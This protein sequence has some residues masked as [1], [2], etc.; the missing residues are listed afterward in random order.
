MGERRGRRRAT[1]I[2]AAR[3]AT[4]PGGRLV[5]RHCVPSYISG[6]DAVQ[7]HQA[8]GPRGR[9]VGPG[10]HSIGTELQPIGRRHHPIGRRIHALGRLKKGQ[11]SSSDAL[12]VPSDGQNEA[13]DAMDPSSDAVD[14]PSDAVDPP[15]DGVFD[16]KERVSVPK[17]EKVSKKWTVVKLVGPALRAGRGFGEALPFV[18]P[19]APASSH[20]GARGATRPTS[21][22]R[23][24]PP[25]LTRF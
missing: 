18:R 11:E 1:K 24:T 10:Q 9:P 21:P 25:P 14:P 3:S 12:S 2:K 17:V 8:I 13:S 6:L 19:T 22:P 4:P 7:P 16:E 20:D 23:A 5:G 15:S